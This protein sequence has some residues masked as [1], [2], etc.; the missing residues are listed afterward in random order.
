MYVIVEY[1][2]KVSQNDHA[3]LTGPLCPT[4]SILSTVRRHVSYSI[5]PLLYFFGYTTGGG[6]FLS[7]NNPENLDPSYKMDLDI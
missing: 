4:V 3:S 5:I 1:W 2:T 7:R 6:V